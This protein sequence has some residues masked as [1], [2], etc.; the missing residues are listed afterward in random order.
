[1]ADV[2]KKE[3]TPACRTGRAGRLNPSLT[4]RGTLRIRCSILPFFFQEKGLGDEFV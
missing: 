2:I 1:M 4:K 3:L